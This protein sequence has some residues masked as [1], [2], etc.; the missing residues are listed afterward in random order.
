MN[1]EK[2]IPWKIFE[3]VKNRKAVKKCLCIIV[4]PGIGGYSQ[5]V[6]HFDINSLAPSSPK[7]KAKNN[8]RKEWP[9]LMLQ[10]NAG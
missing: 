10:E 3:N 4:T 9:L 2:K 6:G 8:R 5:T 1:R 7:G